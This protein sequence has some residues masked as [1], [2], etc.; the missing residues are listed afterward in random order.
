MA[1]LEEL[2][3]SPYMYVGLFVGVVIMAIALTLYWFLTKPKDL[4]K[5][6]KKAC[7]C[8]SGVCNGGKCS[9]QSNVPAGSTTCTTGTLAANSGCL[10]GQTC[11]A[12]DPTVFGGPGYC[13]GASTERECVFNENTCVVG[14]D[15][16]V[17]NPSCPDS[18]KDPT[19]WKTCK[20]ETGMPTGYGL[21]TGN[22]CNATVGS[23]VP[24]GVGG[25]CS[26]TTGAGT[27]GPTVCNLT[28]A[29]PVPCASGT[30]CSVTTGAGV[31]NGGAPPSK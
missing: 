11:V 16:D 28:A 5:A 18:D 7:D 10:T 9:A 12:V 4:G 26:S 14:K 22:V 24:C 19:L 23:L 3:K 29:T 8:T 30:H 2:F 17:S 15:A 25:L 31:C 21:C 20:Q 1:F 13:A 6:C 27:C